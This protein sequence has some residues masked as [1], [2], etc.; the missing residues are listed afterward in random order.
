VINEMRKEFRQLTGY[1]LSP[2]EIRRLLLSQVVRPD[3][4]EAAGG[5]RAVPKPAKKRGRPPKA[6][7]TEIQP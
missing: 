1:R 2:E 3:V 5:A 6:P 7:P 4:A